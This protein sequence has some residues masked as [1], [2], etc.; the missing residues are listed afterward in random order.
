MSYIIVSDI[1]L[2]SSICHSRQFCDFLK[3]VRQL[4]EQNETVRYGDKD[5]TVTSPEKLILL[6]DI[7]E[8]WDPR[9]GDRDN[10]VKE[11]LLPY[12]LLSDIE[13]DK[14]YVVGNHD[15]SISQYET[16]INYQLLANSRRLDIYDGHYPEEPLRIGDQNYFFLHGHQFDKEQAILARVSD[17][18]GEKWDPVKWF[19]DL[20]NITFTKKHWKV[21]LF[22]F[23]A[24]LVGGYL[25]Y[26]KGISQISFGSTLFWALIL[27]FFAISSFPGVVA[28]AQRRI[29]DYHKPKDRTAQQIIE[30]GYYQSKKDT[31]SSNVAVVF[32]HTHFPSSYRGE[33]GGGKLFINTGSWV[34]GKEKIDGK[35]RYADTFV[36]LDE[37]GAYIM[38]WVNGGV[39]CLVDCIHYDGSSWPNVE[40]A[41]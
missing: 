26:L 6:G 29:Y 13:S 35:P 24:L 38:Q 8:L 21:S 3:W 32:G 41:K 37:S 4:D 33:K 31:I 9:N 39:K 40:P 2:G 11:S 36:Y 5:I 22:V 30:D 25:A 12:S 27:G 17:V 20:F 15:D 23:I 14:I 18:L 34:D 1:H 19:Q 28:K 10:V 16:K 7:L